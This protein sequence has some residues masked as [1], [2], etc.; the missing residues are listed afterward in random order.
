MDR[1][2]HAR[3]ENSDNIG[4]S[5]QRHPAVDGVMSLSRL[6][7]GFDSPWGRQQELYARGTCSVRVRH[8]ANKRDREASAAGECSVSAIDQISTDVVINR[9]QCSSLFRANQ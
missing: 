5:R 4:L 3:T 2:G 6:K 7:Q 9:R 1:G 8:P